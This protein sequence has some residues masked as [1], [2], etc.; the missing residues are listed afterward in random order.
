MDALDLDVALPLRP[1]RLELALAV[2]RETVALVGPSGA[3]KTSVLR[4]SPASPGPSA[5]ASRSTV[6]SSSTRRRGID[7]PP[8]DR[9]VGLRLPGV[10]ALP[11]HDRRA[12]RRVRRRQA[13]RRDA[14]APRDH[15]AGE[16]PPGRA[17]RRRAPAGRARPRARARA[18]R[19]PPRRADVRARHAHAGRASARSSGAR[20]TE[21]DLPV[22]LVTH[23]FQDAAVLAERVGV[24]V[25]GRLLQ[26]GTPGELVASPGRRVRRELHRRERPRRPRAPRRRA[27]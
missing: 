13:G 11:A 12:E 17:L 2:G 15:G 8:E 19:P 18:G 26:V 23:D 1:F 24:L 27:G 5:A 6:A 20:S 3:G 14:R 9:R 21:L 16:G 10:R 4:R 25:D 7:L 22:L